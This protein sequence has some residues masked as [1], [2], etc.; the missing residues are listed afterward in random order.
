MGE[1]DEE[2]QF[3]DAAHGNTHGM[4]WRDGPYDT[5]TSLHYLSKN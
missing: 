2:R 1:R 3:V 5:V 4:A